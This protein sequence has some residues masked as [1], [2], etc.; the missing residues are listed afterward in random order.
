MPAIER[1]SFDSETETFTVELV[2]GQRITWGE[3]LDTIEAYESDHEKEWNI[4]FL[5]KGTGNGEYAKGLG[6]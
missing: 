4:R 6:G 5:E 1:A 2:T 3:V